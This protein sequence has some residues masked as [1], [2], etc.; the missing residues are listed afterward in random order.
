[1]LHFLLWASVL[2]AAFAEPPAP[3]AGLAEP[4]AEE[5]TLRKAGVEIDGPGLLDFFRRRTLTDADREAIQKQITRLGDDSFVV[6]EKASQD[7][8]KLGTKAVTMLRQAAK[9]TDPEVMWRAKQ[10]LKAIHEVE[11]SGQLPAAAAR[12]IAWK[13]P[14]GAALVL[15]AYLPFAED[16]SAAEPVRAALAAVALPGGQPD[17]ALVAAFHDKVA[18]RRLAAAEALCRAGAGDRVPGLRDLLKDP[19]PTVRLKVALALA[20]AKDKSA[21]PVLIDLLTALPQGHAWQAEDLLCRLA[22]DQAPAAPLGSDDATRKKCRDAWA[23]WWAKNGAQV[24]MA[25][26]TEAE[27]LLGYTLVTML[28]GDA[29]QQ[30]TGQVLEL[31]PDN[32]VRWHIKNLGFPLDAEAVPGDRV[33][34]C[35]QIAGK[36]TERNSKGEVVW[37][38][39][40]Q[41]PVM[42]QRLRNGNT[43]IATMSQFVEVDRT[44]KEVFSHPVPDGV[45]KA[46]R[47]PNGDIGY[48]SQSGRYVRINSDGKELHSFPINIGYWGGRLDVLANG[49]VVVPESNNNRVA[50]YDTEGHVVWEAQVNQAIAAS[51][52][53]NGNTLVTSYGQ[54]TGVEIDRL[55]KVVWSYTGEARVNRMFRR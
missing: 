34:V 33:L 47:L 54:K 46:R 14:P 45:M 25:K 22:G 55:G 23:G 42:A 32:R 5:Q 40:I 6:R 19:E 20:N 48:G 51:R 15:L 31:G 7:L 9:D 16:E 4:V 30:T 17:P 35:E 2:P 26:L 53:P 44:G 10:C 52:L 27:K 49:H 50:E 43:F 1:M 29:N 12:V 13:K 24:N 21:V 36:V 39:Q 38:K 28:D 37:E 41:N 18:A 3:A 8:V 11:T